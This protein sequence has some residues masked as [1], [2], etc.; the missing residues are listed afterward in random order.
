MASEKEKYEGQLRKF[1][2]RCKGLDESLQPFFSQLFSR[3]AFVTSS[4]FSIVDKMK[5]LD[6]VC[7]KT[8]IS[9]MDDEALAK[10]VGSLCVNDAS[11]NAEYVLND[12]VVSY[13][14]KVLS[15]EFYDPDRKMSVSDL[16]DMG[17]FNYLSFLNAFDL[18][19]LKDTRIDRSSFEHFMSSFLKELVPDISS[20]SP[21][22]LRFVLVKDVSAHLGFT[23]KSWVQILYL[24]MRIM[25]KIHVLAYEAIQ[26]N[27]PEYYSLLEKIQYFER[28]ASARKEF[29]DK[30][31]M[32]ETTESFIDFL[33][34][35][36]TA[37]TETSSL[38]KNNMTSLQLLE[39]E[40]SQLD[41]LILSSK[42]NSKAAMDFFKQYR[43][44]NNLSDDCKK[45]CDMGLRFQSAFEQFLDA[46]MGRENTYQLALK[47]GVQLLKVLSP[48]AFPNVPLD[49]KSSSNS[50][51]PRSHRTPRDDSS[52]RVLG[53]NSPRN[54]PRDPLRSS[55]GMQSLGEKDST[56]AA[57]MEMWKRRKSVGGGVAPHA[58]GAPALI[59]AST[60]DVK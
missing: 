28:F 51:T 3:D 2:L 58:V 35:D 27:L 49:P 39:F 59:R 6:G 44:K 41:A 17:D 31:Q 24:V 14:K 26:E 29:L 9:A 32:P 1:L 25:Q 48:E 34:I 21:E 42:A 56:R 60:S 46:V 7:V 20:D 8:L 23:V 40:I 52:P 5:S 15:R 36:F 22:I 57:Q 47:T 37:I 11:P 45:F 10:I 38:D 55:A 19:H 12:G 43:L 53:R 33:R 18:P 54:S 50:S 13:N 30:K 16:R 4:L